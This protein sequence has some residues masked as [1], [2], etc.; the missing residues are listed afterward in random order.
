MT[1][2]NLPNRGWLLILLT[3]LLAACTNPFFSSLLG[4]NETAN[5]AIYTV[6]FML[7][8]GTETVYAVKTVTAP[9]TAIGAADFPANPADRSEYHFAGWN[10]AADGSGTGFDAAT[11]LGADTT[12]YAQWTGDA[13]TVTF[14]SGYGENDTLYTKTVT[15]PATTLADFPAAPS[16]TDYAFTA[17]NTQPG[18]GGT[19]FDETSAVSGDMTVYAQWLRSWTVTFDHDGGDV[20]A[21]PATKAVTDPATT[22]DSLPALPSKTGYNFGGWY[23]APGGGGTAFDAAATISASITVYAKW[24]AYSWTVTF[25]EN[26]GDTPANPATKIVASPAATVVS[27]PA[28]PAKAGSVFMG[29]NTEQNGGGSKFTETTI[30]SGNIRVYAQWDVYDITLNLDLGD[31]AFSE[32]DFTLAKSGTGGNPSSRTVS[33]TGADYTDPRWYVGETLAGTAMSITIDAA[34]Y[35]VGGH[36]LSLFISKGG[37]TWSKEIEFTVTN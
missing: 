13:Y 35:H 34:D 21:D 12:V 28:Q 18:G 15:L 26:G 22:I 10:T 29:W 24:D 36:N 8:D 5:P 27:L 30:V 3:V 11:T 25:D 2:N 6:T 20:A 4:D 16:R 37:V 19:A 9:A 14:K 23:T 1:M 7:N 17:W 33:V 32:T 31:G